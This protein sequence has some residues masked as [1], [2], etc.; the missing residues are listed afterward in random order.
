MFAANLTSA[1]FENAYEI[2]IKQQPD[3][4]KEMIEQNAAKV[5]L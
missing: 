3:Q 1:I 4:V 5:I 2:N